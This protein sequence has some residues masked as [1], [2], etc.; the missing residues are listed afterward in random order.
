[1]KNLQV[2]I[3]KLGQMI[4]VGL[5]FYNVGQAAVF[6]YTQDYLAADN[7]RP[8]SISLP[9]QKEAFTEQ[10]TKNFFEGL[11]PEGFTRRAVAQW[12]R[13]DESDYV[14]ILKGLGSECL[15]AIQIIDA[16]YNGTSRYEQLTLAEVQALAN[17]GAVK[18]AAIMTETHLSLAGASGKVGLYYD[19]PTA[20]WFLPKGLAPSTHIVKQSHVRLK[21]IVANEQLALM[22]A[23]KLGIKVAESFIVNLGA[24]EDENVLLASKRYD[25][26]FVTASKVVDNLPCPLRLHQEDF[27]QALGIAAID[28]YERKGDNYLLKIFELLRKYSA[29]PLEDRLELWNRLIFNFLIGNTDGHIKNFALLY[30]SDLQNIR[31]ASAYDLVSTTVYKQGTRNMS[32]Y[33]ANECLIDNMTKATIIRSARDISMGSKLA[34]R[35][36]DS[37]ASNFIKALHQSVEELEKQGFTNAE[38]IAEMI[39]QSGGIAKFL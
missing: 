11:L 9:L 24:G 5:L 29:N 7:A 19:E 36:F 12:L 33:I 30:S 28:K 35:A 4:P 3:E 22:T 10:Q 37:M 14:A 27:A 1:M 32:L 16:N 26:S 17:E 18:S 31:L 6:K 38:H 15:G 25:R 39:L 21:N 13:V 20:R 23:K 8:I 2:C 34:E